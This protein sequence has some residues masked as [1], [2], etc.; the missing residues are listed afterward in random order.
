MITYSEIAR[1]APFSGMRTYPE[2]ILKC[3]LTLL[4]FTSGALA[5]DNQTTQFS[6]L[7]YEDLDKFQVQNSEGLSGM[8]LF[9]ASANGFDRILVLDL[10]ARRIRRVIDGPGNNSY[11][12]FGPG[13]EEFA[14]ASDRDGNM[15]IYLSSW[16][17]ANQQRLTTNPAA[18][19]NPSFSSKSRGIVY[20]SESGT[21]GGDCDIYYMDLENRA[22]PRRLTRFGKR[23]TVPRLSPDDRFVSYS[24]NR[25]WPGWDVCIFDTRQG[26][27]QCP[28]SGAQTYCRQ[29]YSADGKYMAYSSG[30]FDNID[31]G[32]LDLASGSKNTITKLPGRE[33]DVTWSP[34]GAKIM[35]AAE[36]G[37]KDVF[38]IFIV[39]AD[40][41]E[42]K[43]LV[44][45]PFSL[46]FLSWTSAKTIELES[47]RFKQGIED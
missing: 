40:G 34:E 5:Q 21:P 19:D 46:R 32:I 27:E 37:N 29:A 30:L 14:F 33:Y 45:A 26:K 47:K 12:S 1:P 4:V 25:F 42:V 35:F 6:Q 10:D 7:S 41:S 16:D 20:Y 11:P 17:G 13:G 44:T 23:N 38:N 28:L 3:L 18:D 15:E 31:V 39:N 36:N 9:T 2:F 22:A 8:V 24:T 43:P